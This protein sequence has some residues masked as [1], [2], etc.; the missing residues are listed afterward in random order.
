MILSI[1]IVNWNGKELTKSCIESIVLTNRERV[2]NKEFEIILIDNGS[3]DGSAEYFKSLNLPVKLITN[4]SNIGYAP[5]C[6]TGMK[7]ANGKYILLLGNDTIVLNEALEKC[8]TF[9]E[10]NQDCGAAGC[11]L[12][13]ADGSFQNNCKK[14]PK[15]INGFF[16]YLSLDRFNRDYD[17]A[18]FKYDE[19]RKVEQISTTFLMIR[20]DLLKEIGY[21]NKD[22]KILYNDVDL[23]RRIWSAGYNIYFLHTAEVIHFGSQSTKKAGFRERKIMYSDIYRY[24]RKNFG[25]R[26][27]SLTPVLALRLLLTSIFKG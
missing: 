5:A 17:M 24:Y 27:I 20:Q 4:N 3:D 18:E 23:C 16:I 11:R 6:N 21:F 12:L 9:L 10:E 14:F 19:T 2:E 1:I 15:L 22:Y 8:I 25:L 13:N 7:K 26:A